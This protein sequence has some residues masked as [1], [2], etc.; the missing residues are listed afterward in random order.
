MHN[1]ANDLLVAFRC[2]Q[3][4]LPWH[5]ENSTNDPLGC[6][7]LPVNNGERNGPYAHIVNLASTL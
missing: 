3:G 5:S 6:E 4:L 1:T 2:S 7:V